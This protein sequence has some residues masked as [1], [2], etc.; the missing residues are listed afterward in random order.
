M[1]F[2]KDLNNSVFSIAT[3]EKKN[4]LR[5]EIDNERHINDGDIEGLLGFTMAKSYSVSFNFLEDHLPYL[6]PSNELI[7]EIMTELCQ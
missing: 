6:C 1:N 5:F 3:K 4:S 2:L 7:S